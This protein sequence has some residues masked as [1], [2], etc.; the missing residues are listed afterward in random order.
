[1]WRISADSKTDAALNSALRRISSFNDII[2]PFVPP[3]FR[4]ASPRPART[5]SGTGR[6]G[7]S[8]LTLPGAPG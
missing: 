4:P 7:A 1:V 5:I 3:T 8:D 2:P 6:P